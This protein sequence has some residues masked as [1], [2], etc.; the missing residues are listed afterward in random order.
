MQA[1]YQAIDAFTGHPELYEIALHSAVAFVRSVLPRVEAEDRQRR[2]E[3]AD[4]QLTQQP[5]NQQNP[6]NRS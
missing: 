6:S 1:H 2:L 4:Q 5:P 3:A